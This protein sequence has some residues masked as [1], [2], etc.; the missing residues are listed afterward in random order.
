MLG[1]DGHKVTTCLSVEEAITVLDSQSFDLVI[2]DIIMKDLNKDGTKLAQ[3]VKQKNPKFPVLAITSGLEFEAPGY[4][5]YVNR[6]VNE[7][8]MKG[9]T[10]EQLVAAINRVTA[11]AK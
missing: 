2:T 10:K 1:M 7:T 5:D 4:L 11:A 8:L 9:F 6:F 3:H